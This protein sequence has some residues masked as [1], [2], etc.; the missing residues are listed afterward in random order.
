MPASL[1]NTN[2]SDTYVG[3]LHADGQV[4][5]TVNQVVIKDGAGSISSLSIGTLG[6]GATVT[7]TLSADVVAAASTQTNSLVS[8]GGVVAPNTPKAWALFSG[9]DG[10]IKSQFGVGSVSRSTTGSYLIQLSPAMSSVDY[11]VNINVSYNNTGNY[12]L[13]QYV[14]SSAPSPTQEFFAIKTTR[15][16]ATGSASAYD[17]TTVCFTVYH[18]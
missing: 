6:A 16:T 18:L 17:P 2:I 12:T 8:V 14:E 1:L 9:S 7:G 5:P 13:A 11:A 3:L 15:T 10:T 4:L